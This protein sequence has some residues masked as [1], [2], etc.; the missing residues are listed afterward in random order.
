MSPPDSPRTGD[1]RSRKSSPNVSPIT[2]RGSDSHGLSTSSKI[3]VS[4][5]P[6]PRNPQIG[7]FVSISGWREKIGQ[8]NSPAEGEKTT[9]WDDYS[10]EPSAS[11]KPAS[12]TPATAPFCAVADAKEGSI[13]SS[14]G[15]DDV[16]PLFPT[17][18]RMVNKKEENQMPQTREPWKGASGRSAIINPPTDKPRPAGQGVIQPHFKG[19]LKHTTGLRPRPTP[20]RSSPARSSPT[21]DRGLTNR[22]PVEPVLETREIPESPIRPVVPLKVGRNS[23]RSL[24]IRKPSPTP[25]SRLVN[26]TSTPPAEAKVEEPRLPIHRQPSS[27][28]DSPPQLKPSEITEA[29]LLVATQNMNIMNEPGSRFSATTYNTSIP[30]SPP[31]TPRR[32]LDNPPPMPTPTPSILHRKRPVPSAGVFLGPKPPSRKPTPSDIKTTDLQTGTSKSLPMSPPEAEAVDRVALL[33]AKLDQLN[34]RRGNLRTVIHELTHVVQP[35]SIAYDMASRQEIKKTV[36]GLH[37]ES[38]AVAK[39]IHEVGMKLHRAMKRR[40]EESMW[41]PT[42][43]WVRRVTTG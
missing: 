36:E 22:T 3:Y 1:A 17:K 41:E 5:I 28:P 11:G 9:R 40:D 34:R 12:V 23:P 16:Q 33:Q 24:T 15:K 42:G 7:S 19:S 29:Q 13:R 10:G 26:T 20:G 38:A 8:A 31:A 30:E 37:T 2:D 21:T 6:L 35:S 27:P 39:E 25:S 18:L 32:S 4:S 43:L 14:G